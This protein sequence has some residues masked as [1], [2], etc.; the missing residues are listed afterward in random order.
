MAIFKTVLVFSIF[1]LTLALGLRSRYLCDVTWLTAQRWDYFNNFGKDAD[2]KPKM[3][4]MSRWQYSVS[5]HKWRLVLGVNYQAVDP[6]T[7]YEQTEWE[8]SF[9]AERRVRR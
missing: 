2:K 5:V 6:W 1:V 8:R 9:P 4:M 3:G 7:E